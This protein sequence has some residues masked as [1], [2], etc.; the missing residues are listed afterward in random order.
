MNTR[1]SGNHTVSNSSRRVPDASA[2]TILTVTNSRSVVG[3]A[4]I[5][6][7]PIVLAHGL[8]GFDELRLVGK[9]L[10]AVQYWRGIKDAFT[11]KGVKVFTAHVSPSIEHRAEQL[12]N[13]I[14]SGVEGKAVNIIA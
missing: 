12:M 11:M 13:G 14:E 7:H 9:I 4:A 2:L 8:L 3:F 10:P 5:P 6:K 1:I